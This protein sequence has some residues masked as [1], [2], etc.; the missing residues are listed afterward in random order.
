MESTSKKE[1]RRGLF[2]MSMSDKTKK[3]KE[4]VLALDYGGDMG[5]IRH[6]L[7]EVF[8]IWVGVFPKFI[9][10]GKLR[11][12]VS[13]TGMFDDGKTSAEIGGS[14]ITHSEDTYD[15]ALDWGL[16]QLLKYLH[17]IDTIVLDEEFESS[18][19]Q[20]VG[21]INELRTQANVSVEK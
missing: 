14:L 3:I 10:P 8:G 19:K 21:R 20:I 16:R 15:S 13:L 12:N 11:Y 2:E 17:C 9:E 6:K 7:F 1:E 18:V 5:H 4:A